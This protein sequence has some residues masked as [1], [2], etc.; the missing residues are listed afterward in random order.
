MQCLGVVTITPPIL[1]IRKQGQRY[2]LAC[3]ISYKAVSGRGR[4]RT[5]VCSTPRSIPYCFLRRFLF[6]PFCCMK[7]WGEN[8]LHLNNVS[9]IT[10]HKEKARRNQKVL[11]QAMSKFMFHI[12]TPLL[13]L[14]PQLK[15]S[16][17]YKGLA[18]MDIRFPSPEKM[19]TALHE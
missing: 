3:P 16:I 10:I 14:C 12:P 11:N 18:N 1:L 7:L 8:T 9:V 4:T 2:P 13:A 5:H 17:S 19:K 15:F 6:L